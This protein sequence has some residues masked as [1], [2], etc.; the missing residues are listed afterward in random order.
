MTYMNCIVIPELDYWTLW[1]MKMAPNFVFG[2][3]SAGVAD[4]LRRK[5][6]KN[7]TLANWQQPKDEKLKAVPWWA[8][9]WS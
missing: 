5:T 2:C 9:E 3:N 8:G 7:I 4:H 1:A 6:E